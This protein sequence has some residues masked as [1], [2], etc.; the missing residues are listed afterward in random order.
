MRRLHRPT[1]SR[2]RGRAARE[3]G[4]RVVALGHSGA[5]PAYEQAL[6]LRALYGH[7]DGRELIAA[8]IEREFAGRIAV[9]S[10]F[11]AESA[12]LLDLVS[13]VDPATP[14]VFLQTRKLFGATLRYALLLQERLGLTGVRWI[15]PDEVALRFRDPDGRL[16]QRDPDACCRLRKVEPLAR[17]LAGFAAWINGRKRYHGGERENLPTIEAME[18]RVKINPLAHWS[19]E[20]MEAYR[21]ANDLPAHP[22]A[23]QGYLSIG[24]RPCTSRIDEGGDLRSGRWT[25]HTKTEC[26]IHLAGGKLVRTET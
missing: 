26:G 18:G 14:I 24:C 2:E 10:S 11:G 6:S 5:D 23:R 20:A 1:A 16:Y 22:L 13:R 9:T 21:V 3:D 8:M 7:L 4:Y 25:N 12:I 17:A 15:E 19:R